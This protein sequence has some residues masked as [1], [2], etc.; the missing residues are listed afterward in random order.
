[1]RLVCHVGFVV[2]ALPYV[3][4]MAAAP[5]G[6]DLLF[7]GSTT[8]RLVRIL[9]GGADVCVSVTHVDGVVVSA[10]SSTAR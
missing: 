10:P 7:H 8:S 1:M 5:D 9:A 3:I 6:D 2:E 4:P